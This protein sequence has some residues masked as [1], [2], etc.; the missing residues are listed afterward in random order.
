MSA[1]YSKVPVSPQGI[2]SLGITMQVCGV[3]KELGVIVKVL[4]SKDLSVKGEGL[5]ESINESF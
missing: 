5:N 2:P 1:S 3:T 4:P